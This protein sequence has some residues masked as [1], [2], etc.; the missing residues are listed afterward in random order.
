MYFQMNGCNCLRQ[1]FFL[2]GYPVWCCS[3]RTVSMG[4]CGYIQWTNGSA[5]LN[6]YLLSGVI[7]SETRSSKKGKSGREEAKAGC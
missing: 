6:S 2:S 1:N 5:Q 7:V 4:S 3:I